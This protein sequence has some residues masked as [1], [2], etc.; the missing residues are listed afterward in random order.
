MN[1]PELIKHELNIETYV[2]VGP[3]KFG[4]PVQAVRNLIQSPVTTFM[5]SELSEMPTDA[6]DPFGIHVYYKLPGI[7][8]A[9]EFFNSEIHLSFQGISLFSQPFR[10]LKDWF[11]KIDSFIEIDY[12]GLTSLKHG[13]GFYAPG[14]AENDES[15][16]EGVIVFEEGYYKLSKKRPLEFRSDLY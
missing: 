9:I 7:C 11:R 14:A 15:R 10:M 2:G 16:V 13:I 12:D 1:I 5:K 8:K 4:M 6:F 3:I